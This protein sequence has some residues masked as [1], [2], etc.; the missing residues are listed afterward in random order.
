MKQCRKA[1]ITALVAISILAIALPAFAFSNTMAA[2][3]YTGQVLSVVNYVDTA[4]SFYYTGTAYAQGVSVELR[5]YY[6]TSGGSGSISV[7]VWYKDRINGWTYYTG[8]ALMV[9][10]S[11]TNKTNTTVN[12]MAPAGIPIAVR[13]VNNGG[14]RMGGDFTIR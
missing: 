13:F 3:P 11:S 12:L 2:L 6:V 4:Y 8:Q 14:G 5:N 1:G 7:Q 9:S 10:T